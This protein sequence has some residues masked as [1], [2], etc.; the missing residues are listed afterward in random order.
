M[1]DQRLITEVVYGEWA[2]LRPWQRA[3]AH[4]LTD[5]TM[6]DWLGQLFPYPPR[7]PMIWVVRSGPGPPPPSP[8][9]L[10]GKPIEVRADAEGCRL[11]V[12]GYPEPGSVFA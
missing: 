7:P 8:P 6:V 4:W 2:R 11:V 9:M 12:D 1:D 3:R 10:L 5:Q